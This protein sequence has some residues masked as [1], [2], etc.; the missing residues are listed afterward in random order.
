MIEAIVVGA[1]GRMGRLLV[2]AILDD[3]EFNLAGAVEA[4][5]NSTVGTDAGGLA[6]RGACGVTVASDLG[7]A[8]ERADVLIEFAAPGCVAEHA[9]TAAAAGCALVIG[10]TG[11]SVAD[12][13]A[14][15]TLAA[16]G[17]RILLA[18]NMSVGINLLFYLCS[19][20]VPILG[21]EYDLEV[22]EL[23]HNRKKDAPSGTAVRLG[24]VLA[25]A[26]G[27]PWPESARHGRQG[28]VGE[29]THREIGMHAI[30]GGDAV[31]DHTVILAAQGERFE[32]THRASSRETFVQGA[33]RAARFIVD[34]APGLYDMQDVLGLRDTNAR[35]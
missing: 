3:P 14:L 4:P 1:A 29:R 34:A 25:E 5:G 22:V 20:V 2:A 17:A 23:H 26:A 33:L 24:E 16:G 19:K 18:P 27:L 28:Q 7:A 9:R 35:S 15:D 30:R 8:V 32:L 31:G 11:L 6:G 12:R 10:T 21:P 13:Q